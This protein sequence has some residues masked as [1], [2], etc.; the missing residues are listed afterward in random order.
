MTLRAVVKTAGFASPLAPDLDA[1]SVLLGGGH[2]QAAP[3]WNPTL[4]CLTAREARRLSPHTRLA[5]SVA[6]QVAPALPEDAG[7]VFASSSGEG[8]TL[9]VIL[10]AISRPDLLIQPLRFQNSVHNAAAGQWTIAAR[11]QG[12][13][14]SI[15]AYD[16]TVGVGL[17]K[18]LMQ[19]ALEQRAVGLIMFDGPL[20][21]PLHE[22]RPVD[23]AMALAMALAPASTAAS[24]DLAVIEGRLVDEV[25]E[26]L[27]PPDNASAGC[28][29]ETGN[30]IA[31]AVPL[32]SAII[33]AG[34]AAATAHVIRL[35]VGGSRALHV[36]VEPV[37]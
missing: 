14:T 13:A 15:A 9:Q 22:K 37:A 27:E 23:C 12:P 35:G 18:A 20:P 17:L 1:F 29:A 34:S 3:N 11:R 19:V 28:F 10:E 32:L 30:P 26:P 5:L 8:E 2:I 25:P 16:E 31:A 33:G 21:P 4:A 7:W 6:E 36:S 24:G